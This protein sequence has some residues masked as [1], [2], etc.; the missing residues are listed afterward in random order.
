MTDSNPILFI[1]SH[2]SWILPVHFQNGQKSKITW[3]RLKD[4]LPELQQLMKY[5]TFKQ[6]LSVITAVT[7]HLEGF[8]IWGRTSAKAG[9]QGKTPS[10][11]YS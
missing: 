5:N 4:S 9:K 7:S 11:S 8:G 1:L 6:Y 2:K 10:L 3:D